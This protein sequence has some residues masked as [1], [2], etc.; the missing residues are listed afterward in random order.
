MFVGF[1]DSDPDLYFNC[2]DL[3]LYLGILPSTSI[4]MKKNLDFFRLSEDLH[5]DPYQYGKDPEHCF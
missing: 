2:M 5:P 1:L 3:A 4:K